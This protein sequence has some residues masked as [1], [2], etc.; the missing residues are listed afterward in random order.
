[1]KKMMVM[2]AAGTLLA[3]AAWAQTPDLQQGEKLEKLQFPAA[4]MELKGWTKFGNSRVYTLPVKAGQHVKIDFA[5]KSKFAYL[6]IFDLASP[7]D[8]AIFG[9][10]EDGETYNTTV[11]QDTTWLL[12][13]YYSKASPRRGLGAPFSILVEPQP[14]S[15]QPATPAPA[16]ADDNKPAPLFP[17]RK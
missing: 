9:T 6:A 8:E 16:P 7:D 2:A 1:M 15:T 3:T 12:R 13:P 5:T 17:P 11:K 10:D 4:T 14:A